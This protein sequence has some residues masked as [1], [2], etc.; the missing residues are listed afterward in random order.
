[1][2]EVGYWLYPPIRSIGEAWQQCQLALKMPY[3]ATM[4]E[5]KSDPES[6]SGIGLQP[7]I[8]QFFPLVGAIITSRV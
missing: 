1:M 7:K 8:N 5:G 4:T 6:V 2:A 3:F